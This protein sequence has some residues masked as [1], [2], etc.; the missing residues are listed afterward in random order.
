VFSEKHPYL[1]KLPK[2]IKEEIVEMMKI[3]PFDFK[4][5]YQDVIKNIKIDADTD[6]RLKELLGNYKVE[7]L[8][9]LAGGLPIE[10][11]QDLSI[12]IKDGERG[13]QINIQCQE[14]IAKRILKYNDGL[15]VLQNSTL[16]VS[17]PKQYLGTKLFTN[18]IITGQKLGISKFTALASKSKNINGYYTLARFGYAMAKEELEILTK[19]AEK[20][21]QIKKVKTIADLMSTE[22][23][24]DFWLKN[25]FSFFAEFDLQ[26]NSE[27][28]R[29]FND[30][31]NEKFLYG[32]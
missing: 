4:E 11:L 13:V 12:S 9:D 28:L 5:S 10:K 20:D 1:E 18:Q 32:Q 22:K 3:K 30:Y 23:G 14:F 27:S 24:R 19:I 8:I 6:L 29:I 7:D 17:E 15:L 26:E 21:K 16:M 31:Y 2:K 25:G